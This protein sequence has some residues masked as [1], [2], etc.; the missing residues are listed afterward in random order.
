LGGVAIDYWAYA[1]RD[2]PIAS[3]LILTSGNAFS[4]PLNAPGVT[5]R[6]WNTVVSALG[7]NNNNNTTTRNRA[8]AAAV[9]SCMR[10]QP[11]A[12]IKAAAAAIRPSAST[13]VLRSVP[14][15]YP[16]VDNELVFPDYVARTAAGLFARTPIL[17][18]NT[19]NE[20]GYYRIPAYGNSGVVPTDAQVDAFHLESFTCPV[21]YQ[22]AARKAH[23]VPA[24]VYRYFGDWDN[25]RL[26]STSGAYHGV[27]LHMVFGGSEEVSGLPTT[28]EQRKMT[29]V[30]QKAWCAFANDPWDGLEKE[31][32]WPRWEPGKPTLIELGKDNKAKLNFVEPAVYDALCSNVT[33]GASGLFTATG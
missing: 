4:F 9:M 27:D 29:K 10:S 32:G 22:V 25:T 19:H 28:A 23:G 17:G 8:A 6:N 33:M 30:M 20:A 3:G 21:G 13:S 14:A 1:Y 26:Y 31:M 24:W 16:Q 11:W 5:D 2:D 15:F 18:G 7:C 12:A